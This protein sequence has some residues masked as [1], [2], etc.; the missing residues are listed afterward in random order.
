MHGIH[1]YILIFIL[2]LS[3]VS[4]GERISFEYLK[5]LLLKRN[6]NIKIS[7]SEIFIAKEKYNIA[8]SYIF[9]TITLDF[10]NE[11]LKDL[12]KSPTYINGQYYI[13]STGYTSSLSLRF[14]YLL[15]DFGGRKY[16]LDMYRAYIETT[17]LNLTSTIERQILDLLDNYYKVLISQEKLN[18]FGKLRRLYINLYELNQKL[19]EIGLISKE[20]VI[21]VAIKLADIST[22]IETLRQKKQSIINNIS[23]LVNEDIKDTYF[24]NFKEEIDG[25]DIDIKVEGLPEI[26][27]YDSK[28]KSKKFQL[29]SERAN[30]FPMIKLF[31]RYSMSNFDRNSYGKTVD[32]LRPVNWGIGFTVSFVLF[33]GFKTTHTIMQIKKEIEKLKLEK[34]LILKKKKIEIKNNYADIKYNKQKIKQIE[35]KIKNIAEDIKDKKRLYKVGKESKINL[36]QKEIE[37]VNEKLNLKLLEIQ[38]LYMAKKLKILEEFSIE[39]RSGSN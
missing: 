8:K 33:D 7:K 6:L 20:N 17:K 1:R 13:G 34:K 10:Y 19:Y 9:P 37:L 32:G 22:Q 18:A 36:I 12:I 25:K 14:N 2:I 35:E 24:E 31:G 28:I 4:Y 27:L 3:S 5:Y 16:N 39:H 38:N 29:K 26:I 11:Y 23:L 30:Y 21:N 15:F